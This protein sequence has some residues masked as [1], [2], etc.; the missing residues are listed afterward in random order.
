MPTVGGLEVDQL[1]P[2]LG[3]VE[4]R[5]QPRPDALQRRV[6]V[7]QERD[8]RGVE[9]VALLK[10]RLECQRVGDTGV[11]VMRRVSMGIKVAVCDPLPTYRR[12][13]RAILSDLGLSLDVRRSP[14]TWPRGRRGRT[15]MSPSSPW[16]RR[17]RTRGGI[18]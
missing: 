12:G 17:S 6:L 10:Q 1:V 13:V 8:R 15:G 3:A 16:T 18:P 5:V 7:V 14:R 2:D 4:E 9:L 11:K